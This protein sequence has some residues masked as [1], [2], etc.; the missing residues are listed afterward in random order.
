M[1]LSEAAYTPGTIRQFVGHEDGVDATAFSPDGRTIW[2]ASRDN[3]IRLWDIETGNEIR[4]IELQEGQIAKWA[5]AFSPNRR[6]VLLG[7]EDHSLV[8]LDLEAGEIIQRMTGHTSPV[9]M[10]AI[11]SDG[12]TALQSHSVQQQGL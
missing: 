1:A 2:S 11:S 10:V 5:A 8:L 9:Q 4:Q 12:Q 6:R 3:T 7:L